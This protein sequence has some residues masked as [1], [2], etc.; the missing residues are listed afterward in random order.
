MSSFAAA[1]SYRK[2]MRLVRT[3]AMR[4][5]VVIMLAGALYLP[6]GR[7]QQVAVR[8]GALE[9]R[10]AQHE[11]DA[12]QHD[13]DPARGRARVEPALTGYTGLISI[14]NAGFFSLGALVAS[15]VGIKWV[16]VPFPV[17][18]LLAGLAGAVVG[19]LVGLPALRIR[20]ST[21]CW[22]RSGCTT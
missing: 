2:Q 17:A 16:H 13:A 5:W 4:I 20:A 14:G 12:V 11:H 18:V 22:R 19:A 3:N 8:V 15:A 6:V 1:T 10:P 7:L 21:C 9:A